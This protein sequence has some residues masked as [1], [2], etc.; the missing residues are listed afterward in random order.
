MNP[1]N[2]MNIL[3]EFNFTCKTFKSFMVIINIILVICFCFNP[4]RKPLENICYLKRVIHT[5]IFE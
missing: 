1:N 3:F 4:K 5:A 2:I